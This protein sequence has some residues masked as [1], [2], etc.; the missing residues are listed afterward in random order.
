MS[1]SANNSNTAPPGTPQ[2]NPSSS[3]KAKG[4]EKETL[5]WQGSFSGRAMFGTWASNALISIAVLIV[6]FIFPILGPMT[7]LIGL[8]F[9][10]I[11]WLV[12]GSIFLYRRLSIRY[13]VS[14]QRLV[15]QR[16]ILMR[17]TDR[18]EL[19]DI[20][21]ISFSQG[22]VQRMLGVGT[23]TIS[24]SDKTHPVLVMLGI[25]DVTKV[26]AII[27]DARRSER[28]KHSLHIEAI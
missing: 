14:T 8:G 2:G 19:I 5:L 25:E 1:N 7:W 18:I 23:I 6:S 13:E 16:G 24:G 3:S 4:D 20:D 9:I 15:H 28:R 12:T 22:L 11:L 27:D 17:V 10:L 21:D 26:A